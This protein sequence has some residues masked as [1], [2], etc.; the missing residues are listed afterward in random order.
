MYSS[1]VLLGI[2]TNSVLAGNSK[3]EAFTIMF[4]KTP[5]LSLIS[6]DFFYILPVL[7]CISVV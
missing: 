7:F 2:L 3:G 1:P 5:Q 4:L 6:A